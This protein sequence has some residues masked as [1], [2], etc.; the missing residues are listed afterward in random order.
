MLSRYRSW[1]NSSGDEGSSLLM[2]QHDAY[3]TRAKSS[4][5]SDAALLSALW[6]LPS[7][8][9]VAIGIGPKSHITC[10]QFEITFVAISCQIE[11]VQERS[12]ATLGSI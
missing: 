10:S 12:D 11:A 6:G 9:M 1:L 3:R 8:A 5:Q 2:P 7:G 4:P